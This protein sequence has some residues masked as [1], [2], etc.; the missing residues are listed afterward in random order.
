ML[1]SVLRNV[2]L[3]V[4]A[5]CVAAH[6]A[7]V[8]Q[9]A[10]FA[11]RPLPLSAVRITGGPLKHAQELDAAYLLKLEPDRMLAFYRKRAGLEPKAQP[12]G[13][14]DG[15]GKNLT[16]HIAGHYLSAV[17]LMYAATGDPRFKKRADAIVQGLKE[18]QD[19]HGNGY[20][21]ALEHGE[22]RLAE[23]AQGNIRASAFD[24]NGLWSPWYVLH[25]TFAGLRDAYRYTGNRTA[26]ELETRFAG[27]AEE[28]LAK[29]DET[30]TQRM[31]RTEFGGMNEVLADL[32]ADT[33]D[34][35]WLA[36]SDRFEHRAVVDP[37]ARHQD[38]LAGLHGNTQVPK[39]LGSLKRYVWTGAKTDG[40]AASFF[41]DAVAAHHSFATGGHGH[42]EYF[43][44]PDKLNAQ[45]DGRT[46]ESCNVYNMLKMTRTLFGLHPDPKYAEFEE[47]ALFNHVLGS[48]DPNDGRTC[49]M[50]PVG[51]GVRHEYQDMFGSFTCCVGTG[52]ENHALHGDGIYYEAGN[53]LWVNLYVPSIADWRA[54]GVRLQMETTFPE[55]EAA[56]ITLS[57]KAPHRFS[58]LLRRP[59]WAGTGFA[60][61]VNGRP[62]PATGAPGSYV[63]IARTW[64]TGDSVSLHLP[65]A[66]RLEPLPDNPRRAALM[67]GPLVL[68]GDL[69]P[70]TGRRRGAAPIA[71]PVLLTAGR[72]IADW[73]KPDPARPGGFLV[74]EAATPDGARRPVEFTPFYRLHERTYAIYWDLVTP[75]ELSRPAAPSVR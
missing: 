36:L 30:Q 41:W 47:R 73:L 40:D 16:G 32:Y 35:R 51:R 18:V 29:L 28:I 14:W 22:E 38:I 64:K 63:E 65:K 54:T 26:L 52:M 25:K 31:L 11:A 37:L 55:G 45:V 62:T 6:A 1:I 44:P 13:G 75:G 72:P 9:A 3:F 19:A 59:S 42:D 17:S 4:V 21:G 27:W 7:P 48:I 23:V 8:P 50:V 56:T 46:D 10:P 66:L 39:L 2:G 12:Y 33:G 69:G 70:D 15:D 43:G 49:Y 53:R 24:L 71:V 67:W 20:L 34:R 5:V 74:T 58:L 61:T 60:V 68:A 57:M